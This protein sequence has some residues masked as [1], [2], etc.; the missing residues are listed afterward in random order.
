MHRMLLEAASWQGSK[1]SLWRLLM[2][3]I[4]LVGASSVKFKQKSEATYP[5]KVL[6]AFCHG[7]GSVPVSSAESVE[8]MPG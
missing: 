2:G 8:D 7:V 6:S 1:Y 4:S 5:L 3:D